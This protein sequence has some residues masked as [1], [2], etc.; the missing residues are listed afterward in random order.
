MRGGRTRATPGDG[1]LRVVVVGDSLSYTDER[2]PR[3]P[4]SPG[5]W[6][7]V[8]RDELAARTGR[9]VSMTVVARPAR[10]AADA[11]D[12]LRRDQHVQHDL[13][14]GV[15]A[16]VA[17]WGSY[18][19]A[20][21]G[22]PAALRAVT[23]RVA[24]DGPRRALRRALHRAHPL[25]VRARGARTARTSRSSF[26]R[27]H[28]AALRTLRGLAFGAAGLALGPSSHRAAYYGDRHPG[29]AAR[30]RLQRRLAAGDG[31]P[32]LDVWPL[33]LP[34]AGQLNPDGIHWPASAHD[35]VGRAVAQHL[36]RQLVGV[37]PR[38][39]RPGLD[40]G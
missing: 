22:V 17:A 35:V 20:P 39:P 2:G 18:D 26:V 29:F 19:H 12:T 28:A 38:P 32:V 4:G 27:H 1:P 31:W 33:V 36:H 24:A 6:P 5:V 40:G 10:T 37:A 11:L 34:Y 15:D 21:A 13:L 3:P 16:V 9:P 30:E 8:A 23:E 25:A 14:P 7:T